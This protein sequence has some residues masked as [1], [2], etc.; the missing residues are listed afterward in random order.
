MPSPPSPSRPGS[1]SGLAAGSV[2]AGVLAY[3][4]FAVSTR[5]LGASEAAPVAVLWSWWGFAAAGLTFPVQHWITRTAAASGPGA[6]RAGAATAT[7]LVVAVVLV[8]GAVAWLAR[9]VLFGGDGGFALLAALVSAGAALMGVVRGL[10]AAQDRFV[11]IGA[12][13][14]AENLVRC[15]VAVSLLLLDVGDPFGY[16]VALVLGYVACAGWASAWRA[17]PQPGLPGH[18]TVDAAEVGGAGGFLGTAAAGQVVGHAVLTGGPV[19]LAVMGARP[20]DV[21]VLFATLALY[22]APYTVLQGQVS[23]ATGAL[24]RLVVQGHLDRVARIERGVLGLTL[25]GLVV[26]AGVG[27]WLGPWLVGVV[28][29]A[30]VHVATGV[31]VALALGSVLALAT[32]VQGVVLL[33]YDRPQRTLSAWLLALVPAA[34]ALATVPGSALDA[35]ATAFVVAEGAAL[36]LLVAATHRA[37]ASLSGA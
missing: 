24:T 11:A 26:G 4:F 18:R 27:A 30:G 1:A 37:R 12:L 25:V 21:T 22:R 6:V 31:S 7:R 3:V 8:T 9:D 29:G 10:L 36:V 2:L 5:G 35:V 17:R 20:A 14:V 13:L 32:L 28:F 34:V 23:Q 15:V 16:G 19:L 33:A